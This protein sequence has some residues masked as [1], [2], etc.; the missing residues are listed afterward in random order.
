[1]DTH[2]TWVVVTDGNY[3]KILVDDRDGTGLK[4]LRSDDFAQTSD[5]TY[6]I[7]TS[8]RDVPAEDGIGYFSRLLGEVLAARLQNGE[9]DSLL[10]VSP[11]DQAQALREHLPEQV[12]ARITAV[13]EEDHLR[14]PLDILEEIIHAQLVHSTRSGEG[15]PL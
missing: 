11:P 9:Y 10:L 6:K 8:K 2:T 4:H 14:T 7:I 12:N 3:L 13:L 5:L 15:K 1:M